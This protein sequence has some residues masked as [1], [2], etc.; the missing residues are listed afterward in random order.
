MSKIVVNGLA[1]LN[2]VF[3]CCSCFKNDK[4]SILRF[5]MLCNLTD[6]VMYIIVGGHSG[7]ANGTASF[8][9]NLAFVKYDSKKF[10]VLF[11]LLRVVLL[12]IGFEG[13]ITLCFIVI[14]ILNTLAVLYGAEDGFT[15]KVLG[16]I[17]EVIWIVYDALFATLFVA[18]MTL[19]S[20]IISFVGVIVSKRNKEID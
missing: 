16:L 11:S 20:T 6:I 4:K 12:C 18:F 17:S 8:L 19:I 3:Y 13:L 1:I 14:E 5:Y 9:K 15:I 10:T 2:T 7:L